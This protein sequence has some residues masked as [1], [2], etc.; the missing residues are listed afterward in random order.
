MYGAV[1]HPDIKQT[2]IA[3]EGMEVPLPDRRTLGFGI[4]VAVQLVFQGP[5]CNFFAKLS[6]H[7]LEMVSVLLKLMD[8]ML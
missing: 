2:Q 5:A 3:T 4:Q 6:Q 7:D 1:S 8:F